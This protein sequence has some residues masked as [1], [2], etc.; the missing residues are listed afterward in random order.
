M[1]TLSGLALV[2]A[3]T[4]SPALVRAQAPPDAEQ[5]MLLRLVNDQLKRIEALEA[6][7]AE[8]QQQSPSLALRKLPVWNRRQPYRGA[9]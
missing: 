7:L 1:K 5:E 6:R 4:L 9:G 3:Y 2:L 8:L